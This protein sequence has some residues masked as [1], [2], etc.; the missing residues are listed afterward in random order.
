MF[1]YRIY[2]LQKIKINLYDLCWISTSLI[3]AMVLFEK[4]P[5]IGGRTVE[6]LR[7]SGKILMTLSGIFKK[8]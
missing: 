4:L 2:Q 3:T 7:L 5:L 1:I 6:V 8:R